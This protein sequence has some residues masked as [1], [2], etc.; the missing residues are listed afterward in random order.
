VYGGAG[1][2]AL[3]LQGDHGTRP[4]TMVNSSPA[5]QTILDKFS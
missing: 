3:L 4:A 1:L 5:K 2:V